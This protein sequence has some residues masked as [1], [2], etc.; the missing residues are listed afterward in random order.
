MG[1][2][3]SGLDLALVCPV[4]DETCRPEDDACDEELLPTVARLAQLQD[5]VVVFLLWE[6]FPLELEDETHFGKRVDDTGRKSVPESGF[7]CTFLLRKTDQSL[8]E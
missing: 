4:L 8:S 2:G 1:E 7:Q 6:E 5:L 3:E